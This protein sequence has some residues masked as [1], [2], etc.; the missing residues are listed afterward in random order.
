MEEECKREPEGWQLEKD[1]TYEERET[2][3]K[4][5]EQPLE[6]GK[7]QENVLL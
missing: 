1:L 7:M 3:A 6:A 2:Q 4:G 5:C